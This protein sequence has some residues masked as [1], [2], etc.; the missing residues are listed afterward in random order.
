MSSRPITPGTEEKE[1]ACNSREKSLGERL[2]LIGY[3]TMAIS[4]ALISAYVYLYAAISYGGTGAVWYSHYRVLTTAA[5]GQLSGISFS[6]F[7]FGVVLLI[8]DAESRKRPLQWVSLA[9]FVF[10]HFIAMSW[11]TRA[12]E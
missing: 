1:K 6:G 7:L 3:P 2:F 10:L 9:L 12:W 11:A 5:G 4:S 8:A